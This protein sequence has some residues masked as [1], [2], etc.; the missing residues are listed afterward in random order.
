[1]I[2]QDNNRPTKIT[3]MVGTN[4]FC[5]FYKNDASKNKV[6]QNLKQ[7]KGCACENSPC[8]SLLPPRQ[9]CQKT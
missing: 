1:M 4:F 6:K 9:R 3:T 2:K 5:F 7:S 8:R